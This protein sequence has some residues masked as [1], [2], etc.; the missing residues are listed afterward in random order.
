MAYEGHR[1]VCGEEFHDAVLLTEELHEFLV[2]GVGFLHDPIG[3]VLRHRLVAV[4]RTTFQGEID[5]IGLELVD[6]GLELPEEVVNDSVL[7]SGKSTASTMGCV[8]EV[9]AEDGHGTIIS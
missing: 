9:D 6:E 1:E 3:L 5:T 4:D 8:H 2:T 7:A